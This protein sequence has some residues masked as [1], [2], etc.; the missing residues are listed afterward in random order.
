M[1]RDDSSQQHSLS[2]DLA[3]LDELLDCRG[4]G[5]TR[6]RE[7]SDP[8]N[9]CLP[10]INNSALSAESA[11]VGGRSTCSPSPV[12]LLVTENDPLTA[13][14]NRPPTLPTGDNPNPLC[15]VVEHTMLLCTEVKLT[16]LGS[17]PGQGKS[18][19]RHGTPSRLRFHLTVRADRRY[20]IG[21]GGVRVTVGALMLAATELK[22]TCRSV[23][24]SKVITT[25]GARRRIEAGARR[26]ATPPDRSGGQRLTKWTRPRHRVAIDTA[27]DSTRPVHFLDA[28]LDTTDR[29]AT[30][31]PPRRQA[32]VQ[33]I[34]W[35]WRTNCGVRKTFVRH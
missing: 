35:R 34:C 22:R 16:T 27:R 3:S 13:A 33:K 11:A 2:C 7:R 10:R 14:L 5:V 9:T 25:V 18:N 29:D 32:G 26:P 24:S 19:L 28:A 30:T 31:S 15:M 1:G 6:P 23:P 17:M 12:A 8:A 20:D 21:N 4:R